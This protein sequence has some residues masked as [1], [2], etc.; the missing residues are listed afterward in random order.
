MIKYPKI[1]SYSH[2][3]DGISYIIMHSIIIIINLISIQIILLI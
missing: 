1:N 2:Y 3:K